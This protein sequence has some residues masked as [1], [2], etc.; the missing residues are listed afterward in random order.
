M[1]LAFLAHLGVF[2]AP[3]DRDTG[4]H[5]LPSAIGSE[6]VPGKQKRQHCSSH[7]VK[8][9]SAYSCNCFFLNE[10]L[11][12]KN[13]YDAYRS[14]TCLNMLASAKK[15]RNLKYMH[16]SNIS[17]LIKAMEILNN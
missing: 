1:S 15:M 11:L 17:D 2:R 16:P 6:P 8:P 13:I 5:K 7:S 14:T 10:H 3:K 9:S 4:W 12:F